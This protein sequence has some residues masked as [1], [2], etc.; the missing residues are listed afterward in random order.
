MPSAAIT[1]LEELKA[2]LYRAMQ[3]EHAT[4]PP[5]LTAL[6]SLKPDTNDA[7]RQVLRVIVVEEMLHLT[8]AANL[9]NAIGGEPDLT[10]PGFV[11]N[12][13][14]YLPDGEDDFE[15]GLGPFGKTAIDTFLKIERPAQRPQGLRSAQPLVARDYHADATA[16]GSHPVLNGLHYYSIG[17][18]YT[19]ISEGIVFLEREAQVKGGTI[20]TG[21][22]SRQITSQYYY[23]GG[24]D[25]QPVTNLDS[26]IASIKLVI[27]Q[28]EGEGGGIYDHDSDELAHYYRF[29]ELNEGRY[30]QKGDEPHH[31]TGPILT[32]DWEGAYPVKP[33]VK[34]ADMPDGSEL[35]AAALAFN[36]R[37]GEFLAFLTR[38]FNGEPALLL[39]A[40]PM[41]FAFRDLMIE[42]IRNPLPGHEGSTAGPTFEIGG[43]TA[44]APKPVAEAVA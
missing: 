8:I 24:G 32:V 5:Y 31:P 25:L 41:M 26:A 21:D 16:L 38:A 42:L 40:V 39:D 14:A 9:L 12:Y 6:Y 19:A 18:F 35:Y 11:P 22:N 29:S 27:E 44:K 28:G 2:F 1:S 37:Y 36:Q 13:P 4:I 10:T 33:N 15:V 20:F 30:Y 3:L 43:G 34:L 7:A 17:E 23:S